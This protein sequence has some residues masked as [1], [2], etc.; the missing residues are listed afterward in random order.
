MH[1]Y[2]D[3]QN[4]K[5]AVDFQFGLCYTVYK[6]RTNVCA[7]AG[8]LGYKT[9]TVSDEGGNLAFGRIAALRFLLKVTQK[10]KAGYGYGTSFHE[11]E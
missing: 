3:R 9:D 1:L 7:A 10:Q 2:S 6:Y 4:R 5:L 11:R 8:G